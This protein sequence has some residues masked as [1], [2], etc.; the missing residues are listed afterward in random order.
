M[1]NSQSLSSMDRGYTS[2][3]MPASKRILM[4]D[5]LWPY[6][7]IQSTSLGLKATDLETYSASQCEYST[8]SQQERRLFEALL[9][10]WGW[11][12]SITC[13]ALL[14]SC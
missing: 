4:I 8:C 11:I 3:R 1:R 12:A 9:Y 14:H 2:I 7:E 6:E 13:S 10:F 5:Q